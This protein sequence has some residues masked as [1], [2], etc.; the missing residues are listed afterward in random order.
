MKKKEEKKK[1]ETVRLLL[2]AGGGTI[3]VEKMENNKGRQKRQVK[4]R[5][6]VTLFL[7]LAPP[8]QSFPRE[9]MGH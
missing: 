6:T 2:P 9:E 1:R 5:W 3:L 8:T 7:C 4:G